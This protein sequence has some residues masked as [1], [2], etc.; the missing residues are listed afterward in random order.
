MRALHLALLVM[1]TSGCVRTR[2]RPPKVEGPAG[3]IPVEVL[4]G[5]SGYEWEVFAGNEHVCTSPCQGFAEPGRPLMLRSG[6]DHIQLGYG[7]EAY[8]NLGPIRIRAVGTDHGSQVTGITFTSL[9]GMALI[10]GGALSLV[11]LG[12]DRP[13]LA[14]AGFATLGGGAVLTAVG[15]TLLLNSF[16]HPEFFVFDGERP[17]KVVFGPTMVTADF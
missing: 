5:D 8:R 12:S 15:L 14:T 1:L 7:V 2:I 17:V 6:E 3:T 13:G 16:P 9:G 4:S 11:S 10:T